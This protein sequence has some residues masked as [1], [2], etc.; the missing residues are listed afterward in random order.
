MRIKQISVK[1]L[2]G[3]FDH[4]IPLNM[5]DRI[6]IIHGVNGIGKTVLLSL[7]DSIF[8]SK[9][10]KLRQTR[11][12]EIQ[13]DFDDDSY[14]SIK[15]TK[16]ENSR[17]K[18]KIS[19]SFLNFIDSQ[20]ENFSLP[21]INTS[22]LSFPVGIIDD[23]IPELKRIKTKSWLYLPTNEELSLEDV[24]ERFGDI[25]PGEGQEN[26]PNKPDWLKELEKSIN[27]R[28]IESQRLLNVSNLGSSREYRIVS[29]RRVPSLL[30]S[31]VANYSREIAE[32]IQAT[33]AEYG[34]LSQSLDRTFPA[35]VF[36]QKKSHK[37]T[38]EEL[39]DK[40]SSLEKQRNQLIESGLLTKDENPNFQIQD[41]T[42]DDSTRNLLS[43][44]VEDVET[45]LNV[46]TDIAQK[47]ELLQNIINDHFTYKNIRIDQKKGFIFT[48]NNGYN[49]S[50]TELSSGEQNELI[51]LCELLFKTQPNSLI[52]ID[53][54]EISLHVEWQVHYLEDL[55]KIIK[56]INCDILMAT[57]S[58][59]IIN[60]RWDLTVQLKGHNR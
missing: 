38:D 7:I 35:R 25:L 45:K 50:P 17:V 60:D 13:I 3:M 56:L 20:T 27:V 30:L 37:L 22:E 51:M 43:V 32:N 24:L 12:E 44:Y 57:H 55:Q 26:Y 34:K 42:I 6:T 33:L 4:V 5:D 31:A 1:K 54:P 10:Y 29:S 48:T 18:E 21:N 23:L 11:F 53:E 46:F 14:L 19:F 41:R 58:P 28:F 15:K 40:L 16:K 47:T 9:Y 59:D 52:L 36:Q 39:K 49:L 2:F 8:N